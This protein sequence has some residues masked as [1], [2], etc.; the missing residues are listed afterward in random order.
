MPD[1]DIFG[2]TPVTISEPLAEPIT[3]TNTIWQRNQ[4]I[5]KGGHA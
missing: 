5:L 4:F 2:V 1:N 3:L